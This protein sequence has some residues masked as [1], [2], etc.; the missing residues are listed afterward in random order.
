MEV[1]LEGPK[2]PV[3]LRQLPATAA[4]PSML[5]FRER[6]GS[7]EQKKI[8]FITSQQLDCTDRAC[9]MT[10]YH[11]SSRGED[12]TA[13]VAFGREKVR[14]HRQRIGTLIETK[15]S[16]GIRADARS[17]G[18]SR[19]FAPGES[20]MT[21]RKL[22]SRVGPSVP[23]TGAAPSSGH[24]RKP[25]KS[26]RALDPASRHA[27]DLHHLPPP[28]RRLGQTGGSSIPNLDH[29]DGQSDRSLY[30]QSITFGNS[31]MFQV[32]LTSAPGD[33]SSPD[34]PFSFYL[35]DASGNPISGRTA[36]PANRGTSTSRALPAPSTPLPSTIH[37][38]RSR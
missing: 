25:G 33:M 15:T 32:T 37:L 3:Y 20:L 21:T 2:R 31:L 5:F 8:H 38:R 14:S 28:R 35:F 34:T 24:P 1:L 13:T 23:V 22:R 16:N 6:S 19:L 9:Y 7:W 4:A 18:R 12:L 10:P 27:A 11:Q 36:R 26:H 17:T 30:F 29:D